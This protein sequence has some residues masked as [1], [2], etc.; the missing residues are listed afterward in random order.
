[1]PTL[2]DEALSFSLAAEA[3]LIQAG[4]KST[5]IVAVFVPAFSQVVEGRTIGLLK[6]MY[7]LGL[8]LMYLF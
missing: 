4:L 3:A 8:N 1:M 2:G 5:D 7:F 6:G